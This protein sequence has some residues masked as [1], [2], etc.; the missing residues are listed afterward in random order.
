MFLARNSSLARFRN[1]FG[2]IIDL[3]AFKIPTKCIIIDDDIL[4]NEKRLHRKI[5]KVVFSSCR[6]TITF[7]RVVLASQFPIQTLA[8]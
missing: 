4:C 3:M 5:V 2:K 7:F 6:L 8:G 1:D